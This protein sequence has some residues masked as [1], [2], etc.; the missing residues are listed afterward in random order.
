ML[1]SSV[2]CELVLPHF[3]F[4]LLQ[5][6]VERTND[7]LSHTA[8]SGRVDATQ[9]D[10]FLWRYRRKHADVIENQVPFHRVRSIFY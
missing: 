8:H 10:Y 7:M 2:R 5:M 3:N 6:I 9:V 4:L 1:H